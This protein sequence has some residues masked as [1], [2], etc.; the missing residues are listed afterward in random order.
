MERSLVEAS[1]EDPN[2]NQNR[3]SF[4]IGAGVVG[5][6]AAGYGLYKTFEGDGE[7]SGIEGVSFLSELI[8]YTEAAKLGPNEIVFTNA[9]NVPLGKPTDFS[10]A[11][12]DELKVN[13]IPISPPPATWR[14]QMAEKLEADPANQGHKVARSHNVALYFKA[15]L[16]YK[17]E[18]DLVAGIKSG[19][20]KSYLE[21]VKYFL[22]DDLD[23]DLIFGIDGIKLTLLEGALLCKNFKVV[24][25]F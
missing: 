16:G 8:G 4:L 10:R 19:K 14:K 5:A 3:R 13:G 18:P 9:K 1:P 11:I 25:L 6:A 23:I 7:V 2:Q 15:A 17:N 20:I 24:K 21:I 12:P 22:D